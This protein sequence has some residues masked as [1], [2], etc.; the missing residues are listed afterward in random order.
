[1]KRIGFLL[2][3]LLIIILLGVGGLF[4]VGW[5]LNTAPDLSPVTS[6][7]K[8]EKGE[9]LA[10]VAAT[11]EENGIIRSGTLLR[12]ISRWK[13][14]ETGIKAGTYRFKEGMT[15]M[16]V[17]DLLLEGDQIL[18]RVTIPE[19]WTMS[20]IAAHLAEQRITP[21]NGFLSAARDQDLL[22]RYGIPAETAEGYLFPDTYF[23][24][25]EYEPERVVGKMIS[26]FY[27]NLR[28]IAPESEGFS[29]D[30]I[31][32]IVKLA[33][34]VE[35]EYRLEKEAPLIA[36]VFKNRLEAG[37][38]LDSCATVEY[39]ITEIQ[40]KDHP[41][42]LTYDDLEI[43]SDYNTYRYRGLPPGPISNPGKIA[44]EAAIY[45]ADTDY[46][47]FVLKD[48][49]SGSHYFSRDLSEHNR[50]K[51]VYLKGVKAPGN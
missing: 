7:V 48:P 21:A 36:S 28:E 5:Y 1:M 25:K 38:G 45:P 29:G 32:D 30:R 42:F 17:H 31:H 40:G 19:G 33:S 41:K 44:L 12:L 18:Q 35:R 8:V 2:L 14:T 47:Y 20:R 3:T 13:G 51:V 22:D 4:G 50:A 16:E 39:I 49:E 26:T 23:F 6:Q 9:N 11:L 27:E 15:A 34:I 37:V 46:W 43:Q 24:P 10:S